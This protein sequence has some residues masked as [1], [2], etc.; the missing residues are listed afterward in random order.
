VLLHGLELFEELELAVLDLDDNGGLA[1][2][3]VGSG[4]Y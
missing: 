2:G 3:V 4:R 1:H